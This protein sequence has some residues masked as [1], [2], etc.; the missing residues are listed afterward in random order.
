MLAALRRLGMDDLARRIHRSVPRHHRMRHPPFGV[1]AQRIISSAPDTFRFATVALAIDSILRGGIQGAS[2][3][4]GVYRGELSRLINAMAPERPLY[5]FDTFEGFP[6]QDVSDPRDRRFRD[7]SLDMVMGT[8][9]HPES[10][11]ARPGYFPDTARGIE[12]RFAFVML[13][14][15]L[16][17]PTAAGL[18]FFYP[19]MNPGGYLFVDDYNNP[20]SQWAVSKAFNA[21]MADKP[22]WP[23]Q[24]A[25]TWGAIQIRKL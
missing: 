19:R 7:T 9:P 18:E 1:E 17:G 12:A 10:V 3:E 22:E 13:D 25:D 2:A 16:H 24:V 23:V 21:F 5:L 4:V 8:L 20:E 14:V 6:D 15:D 11:I